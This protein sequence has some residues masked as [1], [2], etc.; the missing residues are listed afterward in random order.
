MTGIVELLHAQPREALR[1]LVTMLFQLSLIK[2]K[3]QKVKGVVRG[4]I[5]RKELGNH[6]SSGFKS[7]QEWFRGYS[8]YRKPLFI[9]VTTVFAQYILNQFSLNVKNK[10]GEGGRGR[11]RK[12]DTFIFDEETSG[13]E[14]CHKCI[15]T[16][17]FP[18][19]S[20][21]FLKLNQSD[22]QEYHYYDIFNH[23]LF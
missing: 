9:V 2:Q 7:Q 1:S 11:G 5:G 21:C 6:R 22:L 14:A 8:K 16:P 12:E 3:D 15:S 23:L 10:G 19:L 13:C 20:N 4:L 18:I 17:K